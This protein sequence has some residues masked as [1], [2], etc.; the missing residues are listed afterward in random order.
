MYKAI[1][2]HGR[3]LD[4]DL[5]VFIRSFIQTDTTCYG[6]GTGLTPSSLLHPCGAA[7]FLMLATTTESNTHVI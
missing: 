4:E 5:S 3:I 2:H 6:Q 7:S 1:S